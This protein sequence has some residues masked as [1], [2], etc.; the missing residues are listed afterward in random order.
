MYKKWRFGDAR[1]ERTN[2]DVELVQNEAPHNQHAGDN[3]ARQRTC[4]QHCI[5]VNII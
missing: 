5:V 4:A 1:E 3:K 2:V